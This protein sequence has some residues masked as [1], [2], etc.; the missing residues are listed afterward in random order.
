MITI[1]D[2]KE[3]FH[4]RGLSNLN[5]SYNNHMSNDGMNTIEQH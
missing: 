2:V 4:D 3:I 1:V 5:G